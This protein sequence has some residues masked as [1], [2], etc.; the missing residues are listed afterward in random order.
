MIKIYYVSMFSKIKNFQYWPYNRKLNAE[1]HSYLY[2][3]DF[4]ANRK[5]SFV[6]AK[7]QTLE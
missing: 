6:K 4:F 7:S 5:I 1:V 2:A 3:V